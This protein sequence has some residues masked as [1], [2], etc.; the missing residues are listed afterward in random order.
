MQAMIKAGTE[1]IVH[2][3]PRKIIQEELC[4]AAGSSVVSIL[5]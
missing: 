5:E 3:L 2:H 4:P 1:V